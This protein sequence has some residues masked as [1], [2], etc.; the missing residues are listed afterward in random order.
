[1]GASLRGGLAELL[2]MLYVCG[3]VP[4][5][6]V[7][8][9]GFRLAMVADDRAHVTVRSMPGIAATAGALQSLSG[10][11]RRR[12]SS[13]AATKR[14]RRTHRRFSAPLAGSPD[15][16]EGDDEEKED[17]DEQEVVP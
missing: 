10:P 2:G 16:E 12:G 11:S 9:S 8:P 5:Q 17:E 15:A 13:T 3:G 14:P 1:M 4:C 6:L 7:A